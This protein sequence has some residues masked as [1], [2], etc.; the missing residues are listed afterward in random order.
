M[1]IPKQAPMSFSAR[2]GFIWSHGTLVPLSQPTT[3][4]L[5]HSPPF[6]PRSFDVLPRDA[7]PTRPAH[8]RLSTRTPRPAQS[9]DSVVIVGGGAAGLATAVMLRREGYEGP[10][11][12]L[13]ADD[14]PPCD[15]PNLS[16]DYLAGTAQEDWIALRP[17]GYYAEQRIDLMLAARVSSLD[18]KQKRVQLENGKSVGYGAL[19][20]AT[21][22]DPVY[23]PIPGAEDSRIHYLRS[24]ADS[25]AIVAKAAT[26]K[27]V[28]VVGA[29]FIGLEV[30]A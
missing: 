14:A 25:R 21:G 4:A 2:Q 3:P 5:T 9:P 12:L 11:T 13:S 10:V 22:V 15:R 24:F 7:P 23:L 6:R 20:L 17:A 28:I 26:A 16:K 8:L 1:D 30:A 29:S 27:S 18:T 19:L